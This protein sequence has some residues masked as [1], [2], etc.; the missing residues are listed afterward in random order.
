VILDFGTQGSVEVPGGHG[1]PPSRSRTFGYRS[2]ITLTCAV[3]EPRDP[4]VHKVY[5]VVFEA[6]Q[7]AIAAAQP[8]VRCEQIDRAARAV[9]DR[10][11]YGEFFTHRTGHGLGIQGHEPPYLREGNQEPLEEGMVFSI[12][13]GIYLPGRFG[14]RLE[15]I[16]TAGRSGAELLNVPSASSL[17]T[18]M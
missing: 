11:G 9:I 5:G 4:E 7:A 3:G 16:A 14:V 18:S 12:E 10:A 13:P 15:V 17:S 1:R 6:Q 2:D 8:G